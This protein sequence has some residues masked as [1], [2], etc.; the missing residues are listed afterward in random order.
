MGP[1][2][3]DVYYVGHYGI[4][5]VE[6]VTQKWTTLIWDGISPITI[7]AKPVISVANVTDKNGKFWEY[8]YMALYVEVWDKNGEKVGES[9]VIQFKG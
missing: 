4:P 5:G 7:T 9:P 3:V 8:E 1:Y 6:T 2:T